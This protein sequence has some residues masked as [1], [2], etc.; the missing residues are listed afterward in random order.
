MGERKKV[1]S[2]EIQTQSK[3]LKRVNYVGHN[4]FSRLGKHVWKEV[5][6]EEKKKKIKK[7]IKPQNWPGR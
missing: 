7:K 6:G 4:Y 2:G 5:E 3:P 1:W